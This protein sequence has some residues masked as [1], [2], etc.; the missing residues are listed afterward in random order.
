[1]ITSF[2][3]IEEL[4][5]ELSSKAGNHQK[6]TLLLFQY[7]HKLSVLLTKARHKKWVSETGLGIDETLRLCSCFSPVCFISI[8]PEP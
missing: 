2:T 4:R 6:P 8:S 3:V 7:A 1:M 5:S